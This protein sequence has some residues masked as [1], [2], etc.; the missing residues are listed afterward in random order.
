MENN[1]LNSKSIDFNVNLIQKHLIETA[2]IMFDQ[3]SVHR[4][5]DK[6]THKINN[7]M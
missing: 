5:P 4:G 1:L 2:W 3:L 7:H 6:L